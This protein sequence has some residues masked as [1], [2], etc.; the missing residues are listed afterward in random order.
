[1]RSWMATVYLGSPSVK[2]ITEIAVGNIQGHFAE[3]AAIHQAQQ[4]LLAD[5]RQ[6]GVRQDGIYHAAAALQFRAAAGDQLEHGIGIGERNL[7]VLSDALLYPS[8]LQP[9]DL[10]QDGIGQWYER[11]GDNPTKESCRKSFQQLG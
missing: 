4:D 2:H 11:N 5:P 6:H 10:V 3:R 1:M 8:Q 9:D 7:V